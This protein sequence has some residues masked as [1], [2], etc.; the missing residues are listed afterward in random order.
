[1]KI[2]IIGSGQL[3]RMMIMAGKPLGLSFVTYSP[4]EF[5]SMGEYAAHIRGDYTDQQQLFQMFEQVDVVTYE[6]ENLP[7]ELLANLEQ[8]FVLRPGSKV[9]ATVQDRL[10]EKQCF[11]RL[12]IPTNEYIEVNSVDEVKQ[13]AK[14]LGYP[15]IIK[16]R[17]NGYDGKH[18]YRIHHA[19]DIDSLL[20]DE[21]CSN[22][23]AESFVD[24]EREISVIAVR[25]HHGQCRF[26][27]V[28]ENHHIDGILST[29][30]NRIGDA[31]AKQACEYSKRLL[32]DMGYVGVL[33]IEFFVKQAQLYANE[34][35]PRVHNSGHWTIEGAKTSQFENHIR[36]VAGLPLGSCESIARVRMDN[37]IGKMPDIHSVLANDNA[38][39]HDYE[40]AP[41][42]GRKVGHITT[43]I[44]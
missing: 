11:T 6:H 34:V 36:A 22:C 28:C 19:S 9:I 4:D 26:Y 24:F 15:F 39:Y 35:A 5:T 17:R 21:Q 30:H 8:R 1:M 38:H 33:A 31:I 29:T 41:R 18:Q 43:F 13:A 16:S 27:D 7:S 2:G 10:F 20:S 12:A 44:D 23:I 3:A 32:D 42:P 37:C 40:K 25:D 14:R